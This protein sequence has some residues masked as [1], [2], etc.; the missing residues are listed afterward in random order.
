VC[1]A[2]VF[3][4]ALFGFSIYPYFGIQWY[5]QLLGTIAITPIIVWFVNKFPD[6]GLMK[7]QQFMTDILKFEKTVAEG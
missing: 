5:Y 6:K 4:K 7:A 2:I 1:F 3:P